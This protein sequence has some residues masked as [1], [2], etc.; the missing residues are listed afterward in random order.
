[1]LLAAGA[2]V[3]ALVAATPMIV[4]F[5]ARQKGGDVAS[6]AWCASG[7][8]MEEVSRGETTATLATLGWSGVLTLT[9]VRTNLPGTSV[10]NGGIPDRSSIPFRAV[11]VEDLRVEGTPLPSLSGEVWPRRSLTGEGVSVEGDTVRAMVATEYGEVRLTVDRVAESYDVDAACLCTVQSTAISAT[12]LA[13]RRV[14]ARGRYAAG[15]FSGTVTAEGIPMRVEAERV[16][17]GT[18]TGTFSVDGV[19]ISEIVSAFSPVIPESVRASVTGTLSG[20]GSFA[21]PDGIVFVPVVEGFTVDGLVSGSLS[22]GAFTYP[23][24][25]ETG[26][27]VLVS[28]GEGSADWLSLAEIGPMLP[29]AVVACEDAGFWHHA[30]YDLDGM[31]AAAADNRE[32]G[33]IVRG[34]STLSQQ[35]AKNLF[36]DGERTYAR[37]FRELLYAVELER[38]LRKQRIMTL[39]LNIVEWGPNV[40]GARAAARAYFAKSPAG[41]LPE[42]AAFLASILRNPRTAW[43]RQYRRERPDTAR[44]AFILDGMRDLSDAARAEATARPIHLVPQ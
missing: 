16:D 31:V 9:H 4:P 30:G 18:V 37:K 29:A 21:T 41:L 32:R 44:I 23:G 13:D 27:T 20:T 1:M 2:G 33:K 34:G 14:R 12:P 11:R 5:L 7:L 10:G 24:R 42:E 8:C 38:E 26:G 22:G 35:L 36:L 40:R 19:P 25:D 15:H 6:A 43:E 28:S 3:V 17:G 39:Y